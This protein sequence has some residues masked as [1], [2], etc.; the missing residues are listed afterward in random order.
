MSRPCGCS[1]MRLGD[2]VAVH[3]GK[4]DVDDPDV[5]SHASQQLESADTVGR[6]VYHVARELEHHPEHLARVRAVLDQQHAPAASRGVPAATAAIDVSPRQESAR[7]RT[8][9]AAARV[10]R[11]RSTR[12]SCPRAARRGGGPASAR[13]RDRRARGRACDRPAR[14]CRRRRAEASVRCRTRSRRR[15]STASPPSARSVDADPRRPGGVYLIALVRMLVSTCSSRSA[16]P[17]THTGSVL[18]SICRSSRLSLVKVATARRDASAI[19]SGCRS[20]R[21]L[22]ETTRSTS[23]RSLIRC[24]MW[25]TWRVMTSCARAAGARPGVRQLE[26]AHGVADGAERVCAVRGPASPGTRPSC[27]CRARRGRG[28]CWPRAVR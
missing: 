2:L 20:S 12:R 10:L 14:T 26:H 6:V 16:S 15:V 7:S 3:P 11:P 24:E 5:G 21:I 8:M 9:N 25:A 18:M 23:S 17:S 13:S 22:P 28:C 19:S 1:R 27:G 4:A